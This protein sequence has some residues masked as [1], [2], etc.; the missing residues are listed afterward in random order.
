MA[1]AVALAVSFGYTPRS[2]A[3]GFGASRL[4]RR[5]WELTYADAAI[6]VVSDV[7]LALRPECLAHV[8]MPPTAR[9]ASRGG[10]RGLLVLT[11]GPVADL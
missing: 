4:L 7:V 3:W 10:R 6:G 2:S 5:F 11:A 1:P 9:P 8:R